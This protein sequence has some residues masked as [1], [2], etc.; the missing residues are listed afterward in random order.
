MPDTFHFVHPQ[1]LYLLLLIPLVWLASWRHLN[2]LNRIRDKVHFNPRLSR[3][4]RIGSSSRLVITAAL[5]LGVIAVLILA[6]ARPQV[7]R[8]QVSELVRKLDVIFLLDTSP[9]MQAQ[10]VSPS[11]LERARQFIKEVIIK[12]PLIGRVG[13]VTFSGSSIILSYLTS[14]I[15]NILFYLDYLARQQLSNLGTNLGSAI[16]SGLKVIE[17]AKEKD[18]DLSRSNRKVLVLLSDGEDHGVQLRQALQKAARENLRIYTVGIG[19]AAGGFIPMESEDGKIQFLQDGHGAR[20]VSRLDERT[21]HSIAE[22]TG[23]RF[24][25]S[26]EGSQIGSALREIISQE[27]E[28]TGYRR[29]K[30]WVDLY[31]SLISAAAILF[32]AALTLGKG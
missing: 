11:R 10:D 19:S 14:D 17:N 15:E 9:S 16:E 22:I 2:Y 7:R 23:G 1:A 30:E 20:L 32:V 8:D 3:V 5:F 6:L 25:R 12:E 29:Q 27:R 21:L 28:V 13:L 18:Q 24:Y 4:S 26:Y 31:Q